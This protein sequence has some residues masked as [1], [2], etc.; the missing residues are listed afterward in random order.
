MGGRELKQYCP[1]DEAALEMLEVR[2]GGP[3]R[4]CGLDSENVK[5]HHP[6]A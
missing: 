3:E 5:G 4:R 1:L 6:F 2:P